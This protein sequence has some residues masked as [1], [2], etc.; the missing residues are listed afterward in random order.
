MFSPKTLLKILNLVKTGPNYSPISISV[1]S[2]TMQN[3]T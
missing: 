1:E 2:F 3:W